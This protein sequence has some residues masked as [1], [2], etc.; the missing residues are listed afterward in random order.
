[1]YKLGHS[2]SLSLQAVLLFLLPSLQNVIHSYLVSVVVCKSNCTLYRYMV[3]ISSSVINLGHQPSSP[4]HH[5]ITTSSSSRISCRVARKVE[6]SS[7]SI[8]A[9]CTIPLVTLLLPF[10]AS[11]SSRKGLSAESLVLLFF[12]FESLNAVPLPGSTLPQEVLH[13]INNSTK[14]TSVQQS[15]ISNSRPDSLVY[16]DDGRGLVDLFGKPVYLL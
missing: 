11:P 8:L 2:T 10:V 14:T 13:N 9:G 1:M 15:S 16:V 6:L 3:Q 4:G 12:F 5:C 7:N